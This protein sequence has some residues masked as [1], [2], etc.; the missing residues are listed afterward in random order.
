MMTAT[1]RSLVR[2]LALRPHPE[3]GFYREAWRSHGRIPRNALPRG[4]GGA[5]RFATSILFLLPAGSVSR[6]H[7]VRSDETW[8]YHLGGPLELVELAR[9]GGWRRTVLGPFPA[10]GHLFQHTV[11]GGTWFAAR[12]RRG[13]AF[14]LA[15]C[16]VAPG[17]EF[18]DFE[19]GDARRLAAARPRHAARIRTFA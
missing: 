10:R 16:A 1:V 4:Y 8:Y 5:R 11:R 14:T 9:G 17:F 13:A 7:R 12:P 18:A 6:W 2:S 19:L 15:G 3:G